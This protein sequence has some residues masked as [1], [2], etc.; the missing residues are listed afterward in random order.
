MPG[1]FC[2]SPGEEGPSASAVE[3]GT[4]WRGRPPVFLLEPTQPY[5]LAQSLKRLQNMPRQV[6]GRV[7]PGPVYVRALDQDGS[8]GL[9]RVRAAGERL[10]VEIEGEVD[11]EATL[12]RVR[13]AFALDLDLAGFFGHMDAAD[14][15]M[16]AL[17]RRFAGARP[18]EAFNLWESL[19]WAIIGQQVNI[20]FAYML[21]ESLVRLGGK[22]YGGY[23]AFPAPETVAS[24]RYEDLQA[25]K[26]SR[27]KAEYVIDLARAL[28]EGRLDLESLVAQPFV[29]AVADLTRLRGVGRWTAE[30]VL[31]D[32]GASDALPA[33]DIGIRNAVQRYYG[34]DHQPTGPQVREI[35]R[36]WAPWSSLACYYLW[37]G[38]GSGEERQG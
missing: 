18:I 7:E 14:P 37:L 8:L 31:M 24:L 11:P 2:F 29:Q 19:A 16:A 25:E 10:E 30:C 17:A 15:V 3:P 28:A 20:S 21:K 38:L 12:S 1:Y 23:A 33:D 9:V 13:R 26:Y 27:R 6:V 5:S 35:G 32:A 22:S 4:I 34:L 36:A